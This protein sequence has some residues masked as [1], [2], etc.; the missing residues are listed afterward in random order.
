M[1]LE[2]GWPL[3]EQGTL[4]RFLDVALKCHKA[5]FAGFVQQVIHH[6]QRIDVSLLG[7]LGTSED[8]ANPAGNLLE[9]VK[10]IGDEDGADGGPADGDELRRLDE[11]AE[12]RRAPS[13]SR[14]PHSRTPRQCR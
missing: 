8:A 2:N 3:G 13:D 7:V 10:R 12:I 6:L 14:P 4:V 9:N 1:V 5:F 11:D